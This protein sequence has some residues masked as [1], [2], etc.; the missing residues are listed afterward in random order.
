MTACCDEMEQCSGTRGQRGPNVMGTLKKRWL[1]SIFLID[2]FSCFSPLAFPGP[3][4]HPSPPDCY[5]PCDDKTCLARIYCTWDTRQEPQIHTYYSLHWEQAN[6]QEAN[7]STGTNSSGFIHREHFFNHGE[8]RVWVEAKNQYGSSKSNKSEFKTTEIIKPPPPNVTSHH[9]ESS[10]EINWNSVCD[11]PHLQLSL[12]HCAVRHRTEADQAWPEAEDGFHGTYTLDDPLPCTDYEF[13]VCCACMESLMS[14][15][16][17]IHRVQGTERTPVGEL[18]A[19]RDC[20]TFPASSDC[21][22]IWKRLPK[23]QA[24]GHILGYEVRLSYNNSTTVLVNVSTAE[25][26]GQLACKEMQCHFNSSLKDASSVSVSAYNARGATVPSHL[27]LALPGEEKNEQALF[28]E[29]NKENLTVSWDLQSQLSDTL[30]EYVVQ[31]KQAG[32][33]PGQAFDWVKV[34]KNQTTAFFKGQFKNYTTYQVSLFAV[35]YHNEVRHL[36]SAIGYSLQTTPPSVPSFQV[37]SIA[38]THVTLLWDPIPLFK[39]RGVILYYQIGLDT[40][41]VYNVSAFPQHENKTFQ[42][43]SLTPGQEY[44]VWIKAVTEAGPGEIA[45]ARFKTTLNESFAYFRL[46]GI[47]FLLLICVPCLFCDKVPDPRNSHIFRE[48]KLQISDSTMTWICGHVYEPHPKMSLLEIVEIQPLASKSSLE[49]ISE[50]DGIT[51]PALGDGSSQMDFQ[52]DQ[53]EDAG[54]EVCH[55]TNHKCGTEAYSKIVDSDEER[56]TEDHLSS[57]EEEQCTSGY[58]KHFMPTVSEILE[59]S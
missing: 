46:V 1:L 18:D 21:H 22:L 57:S 2:L 41:K 59:V 3:P 4:A 12:E 15:W 47:M 24:C 53:S 27:A 13:Q 49:K 33:D 10:I 42:L 9:H 19:W 32:C 54:T 34:T 36:L 35:S 8:L 48:M 44:E 23:S 14:S 30:K 51:W 39:Q 50:A 25:P 31:Y 17:A 5:I 37:F 6:R 43:K 11:Y 56:D 16:S 40:H 28:L 45:T 58:E 26:R 20:G 7:V 55:R 29:M 52:D 38:D